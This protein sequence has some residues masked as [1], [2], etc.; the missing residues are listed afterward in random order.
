LA[1]AE[2]AETI[3]AFQANTDEAIAAGVFGSP[4]Y[5]V[6]GELFWGQDRLELLEWHVMGQ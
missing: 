2:S 6:A 1:N 4:T 3:A 5:S